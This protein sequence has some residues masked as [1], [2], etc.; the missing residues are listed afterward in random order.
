M[1]PITKCQLV[2]TKPDTVGQY[3]PITA[4]QAKYLTVG[5]APDFSITQSVTVT[6]GYD[7]KVNMQCENGYQKITHPVNIA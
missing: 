5:P 4:D 7:Y 6:L 3:I 1:C 2:Q